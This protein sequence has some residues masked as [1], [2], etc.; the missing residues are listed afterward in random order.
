MAQSNGSTALHLTEDQADDVLFFARAGQLTELKETLTELVK[1]HGDQ[2]QLDEKS[3]AGQETRG[4]IVA[5]AKN[6]SG[7]TAL[8]YCCANGHE[9]T[10]LG[11][12]PC[13]IADT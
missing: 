12:I 9:G 8:H 13:A 7:N 6:E 5:E 1:A 11:Q 4:K 2:K 10:S 3:Q